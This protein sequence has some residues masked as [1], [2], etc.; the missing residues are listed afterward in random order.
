VLSTIAR[1][2]DARVL[3]FQPAVLSRLLQALQYFGHFIP[4]SILPAALASFHSAPHFF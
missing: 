4:F 1:A 2:D 3:F